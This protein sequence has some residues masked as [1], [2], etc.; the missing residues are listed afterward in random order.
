[1]SKVSKDDILKAVEGMT[2]LELSDLVKALEE[3]FGVSAMPVATATPAASAEG[4]G[5]PKEEQT[6]FNV[7]LAE[8]GANK[9]GVIKAVRELV[10]TLGLQEAKTLVES[11]PKEVLTGQNKSAAEESK[12]KLEAAGAKVELK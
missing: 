4:S 8:A 3:K 6:V 5:E 2:V 11:A 7:V 12:K 1:M 9:I 10:P